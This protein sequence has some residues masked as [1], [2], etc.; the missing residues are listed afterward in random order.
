M[1]L[2]PLLFSSCLALAAAISGP[3]GVSVAGATGPAIGYAAPTPADAADAANAFGA[4]LH[5]RLAK[6][7][8]N[9]F[10]S[11]A[12]VALALGM[13]REGAR[14][15]TATEMDAVLHVT[16]KAPGT[17][18]AL[19]SVQSA[20]DGKSSPEVRVANRLWADATLPLEP[21]YVAVTKGRYG[22]SAQGVDFIRSPEPARAAINAWVAGETRDRIK[23]LL[24]PGSITSDT[25]LTLTNAVYFKG[26]WETKFDAKR[27]APAPFHLDDKR[28]RDVPMMHVDA[29]ARWGATPEADVFELRYQRPKDQPGASMIVVLPKTATGLSAVDDAVARAGFA[30]FV[31]AL[32]GGGHADVALP[33]FKMTRSF[34]LAQPLAAMGMKSGFS[35]SAD[36]SGISKNASLAISRVIHKAFVEV[37]EQGTEAAAATAVVMET[38]AVMVRPSFV[39]DRPFLFLTATRRPARS[40]SRG[41]WSTPPRESTRLGACPSSKTARARCSRRCCPCA[42][43]SAS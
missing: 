24:P 1:T 38:T 33:K 7:P 31:S 22:A 10:W 3:S 21:A 34:E 32:A 37:D 29:R 35:P 11:P 5:A 12:S 40:C 16:G 18:G 4:E 6:E 15:A 26:S 2:R 8:G 42:A 30:P 20:G 39:V 25:R 41:A 19:A 17:L 14:G 36:F 43:A 27:T 9:V 28:T 23:D 13:A